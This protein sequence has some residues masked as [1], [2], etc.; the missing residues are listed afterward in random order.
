[1]MD[2]INLDSTVSYDLT[3]S[4]YCYTPVGAN[5]WGVCTTLRIQFLAKLTLLGSGQ[6]EL[7]LHYLHDLSS[8]VKANNQQISRVE[9]KH[10]VNSQTRKIHQF[11]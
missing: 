7:R 10:R 5:N 4:V 9:N 8:S 2:K 6:S 11:G 3:V 1:M